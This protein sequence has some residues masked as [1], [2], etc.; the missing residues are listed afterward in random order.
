MGQVEKEYLDVDRGNVLFGQQASQPQLAPRAT[1]FSNC[2]KWATFDNTQWR[3][4]PQM[5]GQH[6]W[7]KLLKLPQMGNI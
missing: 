1:N 6:V 7:H 2:L 3:K 4:E 5:L